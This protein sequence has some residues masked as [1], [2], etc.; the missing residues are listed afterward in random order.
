MPKVSIIIPIFNA[1]K[2]LD[3]C[4]KSIQNQTFGDFEAICVDDGSTDNSRSICK[5]WCSIDSR[6][7]YVFQENAG[8]SA[9]RNTGISIAKGQYICFVDADDYLDYHY[10]DELL[11]YIDNCDAVICEWTR[12][13]HLGQ[14]GTFKEMR[15]HS[16]IHDV[17]YERI[18]HPGLYCFLYKES[19][20]EKYNIRFSVGCIKNEDTEFYIKYLAACKNN[21]ALTSY[22][23]YYYRQNTSS[24]MAAPISINSMTSIEASR[25]INNLLYEEGILGDNEIVLCNGILTYTY[26]IARQHNF[27]LYDYL[28]STYDVKHAMIKML[29]FPRISKNIVAITYIVLGKQLFF[30]LIGV[31]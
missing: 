16:L 24:I 12:G 2:F 15:P 17:I 19:I 21:I 28:H 29:S 25:R 27:E 9:A 30:K 20:I 7:E 23:G 5:N 13:Q 1:C 6:F 18:K 11:Q 4:L 10:L 22:V 3:D 26:S 14:K 8:V 31:F